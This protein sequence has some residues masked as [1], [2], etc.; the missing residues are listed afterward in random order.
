MDK[1]EEKAFPFQ[2]QLSQH[3]ARLVR[4]SYISIEFTLCLN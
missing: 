1:F 2:N 3:V 4:R